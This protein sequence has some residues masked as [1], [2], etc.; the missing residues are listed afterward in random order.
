MNRQIFQSKIY[1]VVYFQIS[2]PSNQFDDFF[3]HH[4]FSLF[5]FSNFGTSDFCPLS[6]T[7][8]ITRLTNLLIES[9]PRQKLPSIFSNILAFKQFKTLMDRRVFYSIFFF[10]HELNCI[11][12]CYQTPTNTHTKTEEQYCQDIYLLLYCFN[13]VLFIL[14]SRYLLPRIYIQ[15]I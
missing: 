14:E 8:K 6:D 4:S 7:S 3:E 9:F 15:H 1:D 5:L 2:P 10:Y 12:P 13:P 11:V